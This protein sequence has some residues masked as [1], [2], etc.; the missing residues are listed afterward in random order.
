MALRQTVFRPFTLAFIQLGQIGANKAD[1]L[2]H[3][4]EMIF[5]AT[6]AQGPN[7]K[8]DIV[9]LP[10][11]LPFVCSLSYRRLIIIQECFNS[12]YG[13][14][15]FP[16]YAEDIGF[17]SGKPYNITSSVSE[18]VKMLSDAAKETN[19]W[20]IGGRAPSRSQWKLLIG[21]GS[22]PERDSRDGKLYNTCTV[23]NPKGTTQAL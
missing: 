2:K 22:I 7:K 8:P 16:V 11:R 10:V 12:P 19:T 3:A 15:H 18:S 13:H 9:V 6:S 14:V 5:K 21:V 17:T 4:R 20:L 23:Y 1:N